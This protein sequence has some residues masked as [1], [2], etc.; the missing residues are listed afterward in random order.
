VVEQHQRAAARCRLLPRRAHGLGLL[1]AVRP[2][3]NERLPGRRGLFC[4]ARFCRRPR[5]AAHADAALKDSAAQ[6]QLRVA[7][8]GVVERYTYHGYTVAM[9]RHCLLWQPA[10]AVRSREC[11]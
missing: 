10:C 1:L 4:A 7:E 2:H 6:E 11:A 3:H 5:G 8:V 9:R